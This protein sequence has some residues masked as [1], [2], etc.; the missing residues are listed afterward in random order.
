MLAYQISTNSS[1]PKK[2]KKFPTNFS[3][4][5]FVQASA[6]VLTYPV[7][8]AMDDSTNENR[9]ALAWEKAF[10]QLAK[11]FSHSKNAICDLFLNLEWYVICLS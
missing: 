3:M 7:N 10:I 9:M 1:D 2:K 6:F 11:V 5:F 8:N 4:V